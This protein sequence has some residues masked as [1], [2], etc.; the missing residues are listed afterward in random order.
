MTEYGESFRWG[1]GLNRGAGRTRHMVETLRAPVMILLTSRAEWDYVR[2]MIV[3]ARGTG[4]FKDQV[5]L[6]IVNAPQDFERLHGL[7]MHLVCDH[8][9][10]EWTFSQGIRGEQL[11]VLYW[12]FEA[13]MNSRME[14]TP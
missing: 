13:L 4:F 1:E 8:Y 2:N 14:S 11:R 9:W 6:H 5:K 7:R 10:Y 3:D 12:Q